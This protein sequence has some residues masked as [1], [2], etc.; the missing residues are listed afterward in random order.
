M[1]ADRW[2]YDCLDD[3]SGIANYG[4]F[5]SAKTVLAPLAGNLA[6]DVHGNRVKCQWRRTPSQSQVMNIS[7][8]LCPVDFSPCSDVA[9]KHA[10]ELAR[11]SQATLVV[12]HVTAPPPTYISGHPG[13]G[14][15][16][17]YEPAPDVRLDRLEVEGDGVRLERV[18][19]VGIEGESIVKY[20]E[21]TN[22]DLIV[23][24]THGYSGFTRLLLG[25]VADFV[26][27]HAKCPV[28]VVKD[29]HREQEA[30]ADDTSVVA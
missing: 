24:G 19:L 13:Y 26:L 30:A 18:H 8:V 3:A 15:I 4:K 22:C 7:K 28:F 21:Q 14:A 25:S 2:G 17:P 10:A 12:A 27:R 5:F 16:P 23:M 6:Q 9:F 29:K 11:S 1:H 20:A